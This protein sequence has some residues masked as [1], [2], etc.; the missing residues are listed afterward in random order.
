MSH[1]TDVQLSTYARTDGAGPRSYQS[2]FYQGGTYG[3]SGVNQFLGSTYNYIED[4]F[5]ANPATGLAWA[6]SDLATLQFGAKLT[7]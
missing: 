4:E 2:G 3:Y 1:I 5:P 7:T 6:P